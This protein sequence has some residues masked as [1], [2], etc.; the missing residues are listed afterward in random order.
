VVIV[1]VLNQTDFLVSNVTKSINENSQFI[2]NNSTNQNVAKSFNYWNIKKRYPS[3]SIYWYYLRMIFYVLRYKI[4]LNLLYKI[5]SLED[6]RTLYINSGLKLSFRNLL[7][8]V[9]NLMRNFSK[10]LPVKPG[11][12]V[13][14]IHK[15]VA[16]SPKIT[17][18]AC[19]SDTVS[20]FIC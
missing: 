11:S 14:H 9:S 20:C 6:L 12:W 15:F 2:R 5:N 3:P 18:I 1:L 19:R 16:R 17:N 4:E 8:R 13:Q 7:G 10:L